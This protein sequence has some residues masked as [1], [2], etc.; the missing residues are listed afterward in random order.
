MSRRF[1]LRQRHPL[2]SRSVMLLPSHIETP[3][4]PH[5]HQTR[6]FSFTYHSAPSPRFSLLF[7]FLLKNG[8][9]PLPT[10][11]PFTT[12]S[13]SQD[14]LMSISRVSNGP[15]LLP[16]I[17]QFGLMFFLSFINAIVII[18]MYALIQVNTFSSCSL[19]FFSMKF[20]FAV[21]STYTLTPCQLE[22]NSGH[23]I[24]VCRKCR[25]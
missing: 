3:L 12:F 19:F 17:S 14:L 2:L 24:T 7:T 6:S 18:S 20:V 21:F 8:V 13:A 1:P 4:L 23:K 11:H 25:S 16:S 5:A 10:S 15:S 9:V 22:N